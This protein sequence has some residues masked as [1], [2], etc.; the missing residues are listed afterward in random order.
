MIAQT[1]PAH[2]AFATFRAALKNFASL[3]VTHETGTIRRTAFDNSDTPKT[4]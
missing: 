4:I 2:P 3:S 1:L